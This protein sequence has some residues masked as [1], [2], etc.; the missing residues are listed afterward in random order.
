MNILDITHVIYSD[1]ERQRIPGI[2]AE[3]SFQCMTKH[4]LV[5]FLGPS[6]IERKR[7][8][9][10]R[11]TDI[12]CSSINQSISHHVGQINQENSAIKILAFNK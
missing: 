6:H 2:G 9:N 7:Q 4:S 5:E 12:I 1:Y 10:L 3:L 11:N 8:S